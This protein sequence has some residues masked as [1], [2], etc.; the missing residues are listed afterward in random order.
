MKNITKSYPFAKK[1][2]SKIIF[3]SG[4]TR[5]GKVLVLK[6][7]LVTILVL[8]AIISLPIVVQSGNAHLK[9]ALEWNYFAGVIFFYF[10]T[11]LFWKRF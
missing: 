9:H 7:I 1:N 2:I 5:S 4:N 11:F 10:L 8:V 6:I 3:V